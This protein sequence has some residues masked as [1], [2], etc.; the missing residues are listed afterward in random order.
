MGSGSGE[1]VHAADAKL[2]P[3]AAAS[4]ARAGEPPAPSA[5]AEAAPAGTFRP[6]ESRSERWIL[7]AV[8]LLSFAYLLLFRRY[9][10]MDP[11]EG[12]ILEGAQRVLR[13]QVLYRDFFSFCTPGSYY[14]VALLFKV[15]G[16][17]VLVARSALSICGSVFSALTYLLARRVTSRSNALSAAALT[18]ALS[19]PYRAVVVHNWDSTVW[20]CLALYCAVR[21]L[22]RGPWLWAAGMGGAAALTFLFEQSKGAG[23]ALGLILGW[24]LITLGDRERM[25]PRR[26]FRLGWAGGAAL[27]LLATL[28]YFAR[29]GA[30][31]A[32]VTDLS[33]P[34]FHYT[35]ANQV[36]YGYQNWSDAARASLFLHATFPQKILSL[37]VLTPCFIMPL[38]PLVAL[39]FLVYWCLP[40]RRLGSA[41][42]LRNY[43]LLVGSAM[44]GLLLSVIVVRADIVHFMYLAPLLFLVLAWI[45]DG[46]DIHSALFRAARPWLNY[47]LLICFAG[48][49]LALFLR[50]R[51]A[52]Y[53][54]GSR[55]GELRAA[56]PDQVVPYVQARVA[57]GETMLVYP[58]LPLY[59]Y[60]TATSSPARFDYLQPGM[61]TAAQTREVVERLA[62]APPRAV[63][64][65]L[66]FGQK[67]ATSWPHTPLSSIAADPLGDQLLKRYH[68]C[69]VLL[70]AG[71]WRFLYMTPNGEPCR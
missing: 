51:D 14:F 23:L 36:P 64:F 67:V 39:G 52:P 22:E 6:E 2:N 33:W 16:S 5:G 31:R 44:A 41:R 59:Y 71:G 43:Y 58:Y 65:E 19:I 48:F 3:E 56:R 60:L 28:A 17:S 7:A 70:S 50:T 37:L 53:S 24:T 40:Q 30:L 63:L 1:V 46:R 18:A 32:M 27:P 34:I 15:F 4:L 25:P 38:L 57:A 68:T 12:I 62:S 47:L 13:G 21:A 45:M 54:I 8:A 61:H 35:T 29:R 49:A 10:T 55:R 42:G 11:D 66:G 9:T 69:A 20:A 26:G